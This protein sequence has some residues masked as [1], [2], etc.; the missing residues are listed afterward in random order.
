MTLPN[1]L[2]VGRMI[3]SPIFFILYVFTVMGESIL[4]KGMIALWIIQIVSEVSDVLDGYIARK[5]NMVSDMGKI[6]DPFADVIS[7]V[8]Y[9]VCFAF[10]GLMPLWALMIILWREFCIMFIRMVLAKEGTALAAKWGGKVKAVFYFISGIFGLFVL[11]MKSL[12]SLEFMTEL[13][14]VSQ[15]LF[16]LAAV[17]SLLSFLEYFLLFLKTETMK[18]FI[19]E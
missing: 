1:K 18:Q 2:T 19:K 3:L 17:S 8:T 12:G 7:R 13:I 4:L 6:M 15:V 14:L 5:H 16:I 10:T 9:F 11:T